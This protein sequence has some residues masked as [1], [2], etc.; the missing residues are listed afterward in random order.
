VTGIVVEVGPLT[1]RGPNDADAGLLSAGIEAI[2]DELALVD[3]RAVSVAEVWRTAMHDVVGGWTDEVAVVC[4]TWWPSSR[5]D[6]VSDAARTV[7][8]DVVV[9]RRAQVLGDGCAVVEIAQDF[10]VVSVPGA[11]MHVLAHGDTEALV[12][13]IPDSMPVVLDCPEGVAGARELASAIADHLRANGIAARIADQDRVRRSAEALLSPQ[14]AVPAAEPFLS[15]TRGRRATAVLTGIVLSAAVLCG[16]F[17]AGQDA[18]PSTADV[19]MTL[20]VERRV[21]V[22]VPAR[23]AV[24]RVT[25][26]P[27][28][29]R[30]QVVSPDDTKIALHVTQSPLPPHASL[31]QVAASVRNALDAELPGVFVDFNP[32]DRR[33]DRP[34]VS[35]RELRADRHITWFVL[36]DRS[37]RI[38]IGCQH[39]TERA[40][41]VRAICDEVIRTAH[42][43]F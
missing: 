40:E 32:S 37:V 19:P 14:E 36:I 2:D 21:A 30:V 16:G 4:P 27:G 23:W 6:R 18:H 11:D 7:A 13:K 35:Y 39:P 29:A 41:S 42:A 33:A 17:A 8:D 34:V 24:R 31:E 1:L 38:A 15:T 10:T 9:L 5:V 28:S 26:G 12:S 43:I 20:L 22:M 3:E 25:S